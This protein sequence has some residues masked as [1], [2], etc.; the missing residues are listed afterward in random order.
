VPQ[1]PVIGIAT[2]T[3]EAVPGELPRCWVMGQRYVKSLTSAGAVPWLIPS[4]RDDETT[5]RQIYDHLDGL[6]L[7]GGVDIDP[8]QYGEPRHA[9]CDRSDPDRDW[10]ELR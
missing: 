4:I 9:H 7:T 8:A 5:L 10:T 1:R 3:L 2:Q 6:F